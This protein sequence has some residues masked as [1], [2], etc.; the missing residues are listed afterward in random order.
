VLSFGLQKGLERITKYIMIA[1]LVLMLVMLGRNLTLFCCCRFGWGWD[2]FVQ[3]ANTGSG[4]KNRP[5][6][7]P[8]FQYAL[9]VIIAFVYVYGLA[10]FKGR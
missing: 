10:T 7:R 4:W 9:P 6:M 1:L 8:V 2:H 3:E 5:W